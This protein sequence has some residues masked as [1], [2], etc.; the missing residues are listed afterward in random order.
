MC[1]R[2]AAERP[3]W[4]YRSTAVEN[5]C[6]W[7]VS[8]SFDTDSNHLLPGKENLVDDAILPIG[9]ENLVDDAL[10][11]ILCPACYRDFRLMMSSST[12]ARVAEGTARTF[13]F[14]RHQKTLRDRCELCIDKGGDYVEK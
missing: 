2:F 3:I 7:G 11:P 10:F 9:K 4:T 12:R 6:P 1:R 13:P 5:L 14:Y 8:S